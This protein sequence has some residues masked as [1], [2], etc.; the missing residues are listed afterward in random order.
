MAIPNA[1]KIQDVVD[2]TSPNQERQTVSLEDPSAARSASYQLDHQ[3][4]LL[5]T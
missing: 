2:L 4:L 3:I 5:G 1:R